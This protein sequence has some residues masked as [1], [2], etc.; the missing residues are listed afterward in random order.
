[1][2]EILKFKVCEYEVVILQEKQKLKW[3]VWDKQQLSCPTCGTPKDS[4]VKGPIESSDKYSIWD[5]SSAIEDALLNCCLQRYSVFM[6]PYTI[7][8]NDNNSIPLGITGSLGYEKEY[9]DT[10]GCGKN[11]KCVK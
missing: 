1:M 5:I 9:C 7:T 6:N 3:Q 11:C 2:K 8:W 10:G 4:D